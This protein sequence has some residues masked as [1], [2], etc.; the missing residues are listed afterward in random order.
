MP[1]KTNPLVLF[2]KES[3]LLLLSALVF[4]LLLA[5]INS[6]WS[7]KVAQNKKLKIQ[8]AIVALIPATNTTETIVDNQPV[9]LSDGTAEKISIFKALDKNKKTVGYSFTATGSGYADK[10]DLMIAVDPSLKKSLGYEVIFSNETTGFG[11]KIKN[12]FYRDQY[13]GAPATKLNLKKLGDAT[14]IDDEIIAI[15]GATISST[16]VIDIF[17]KYIDKAKELINK[18]KTQKGLLK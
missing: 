9:T 6:A 13:I 3:W 14:K 1:H 16:A 12:D 17:N 5:G 8:S 10:I 15:S 7:P 18:S 2:I 11:N 4:G